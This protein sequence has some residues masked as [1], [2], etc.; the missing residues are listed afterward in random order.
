[1]RWIGGRTERALDGA[2]AYALLI[3]P[4][5]LLGVLAMAM[6]GVSPVLWGQQVTAWV[7]FALLAQ[8]LRRIAGRI[9]AAAWSALFLLLLVAS[10]FGESV[11]GARRWVNLGVFHANAA[12]LVIPALLVVLGRMKYPCPVALL[13]AVVLCIQ[14]D[15]SQL[16]A[17]SAAALVI[18]WR[19]EKKWLWGSLIILGVLVIRCLRVPVTIEPVSYCEGI[20][21]MLAET[22]WMLQAA[23]YAA[24]AA[25]PA[26]GAYRFCKR[27]EIQ[28][29]SAAVYYAACML[30]AF[31]GGYPVPFMGFGLSPIAGYW[32]A[33]ICGAVGVQQKESD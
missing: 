10:L 32:L 27:G 25:I 18:L 17:F 9:P 4:A 26:F 2:A 11:E 8:L 20:L 33:Y 31:S 14:P 30:F 3:L 28:M 16:T 6:G 5:V 23:G 1:M 12:M 21:A 7:A 29:L 19:Q 13:A 15:L 24:L 22:S